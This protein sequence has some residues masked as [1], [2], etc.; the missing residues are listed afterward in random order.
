[1]VDDIHLQISQ[2]NE[3]WINK[4]K[5]QNKGGK[6]TKTKPNTVGT[7]PT[8]DRQFVGRPL[9]HEYMTAHFPGLISYKWLHWNHTNLC[10]VR[11]DKK[12][13]KSLKEMTRSGFNLNFLNITISCIN[14][15]YFYL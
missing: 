14:I 8:P 3:K 7:V 13:L 15:L 2:A 9:T 12:L 4:K 10:I 11:N 5:S 1:L 6:K